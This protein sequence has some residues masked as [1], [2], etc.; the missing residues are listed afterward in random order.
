MSSSG[1][2]E[3]VADAPAATAPVEIRT[4]SAKPEETTFVAPPGKLSK[5]ATTTEEQD[6]STKGQRRVNFTWEMT[7]SA[8][9][10]MVTCA[11]IY[12]QVI[13]KDSPA[14]NNGFFMV[15]ATYLTRT[16]HTKTGG[17]QPGDSGR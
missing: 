12:T 6:R 17:V 1:D 9:T 10:I 2:G 14:L 3:R 4:A 15:L 16:N 5:V 8:V 7:Q 13:G 11:T